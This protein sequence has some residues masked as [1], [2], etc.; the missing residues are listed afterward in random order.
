MESLRKNFQ[1]PGIGML[2]VVAALFAGG[3]RYPYSIIFAR[4]S[5]LRDGNHL[6]GIFRGSRASTEKNRAK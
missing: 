2:V 3:M 6:H 4:D 5:F 1:W